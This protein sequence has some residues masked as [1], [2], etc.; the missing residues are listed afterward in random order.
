MSQ[1]NAQYIVNPD[2]RS[3]WLRFVVGVTLFV[4]GVT[5][6]ASGYT[7]PVAL[8]TVLRH[9]QTHDIDASPL[10]YTDVENMLDLERR[11]A[12]SRNTPPDRRDIH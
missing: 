1:P 8:G 10:F 7:P 5:F 2:R 6:F 3:R 11:L 9:N 4:L 12:D